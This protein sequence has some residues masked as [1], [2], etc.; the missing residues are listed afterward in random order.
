MV[1]GALVGT[2]VNIGV[3]ATGVLGPGMEEL[4]SEQVA[5]FAKIDAKLESLR[6]ASAD[7]AQAK[8]IAG[9]LQALIAHQKALAERTAEELRGA[10]AQIE[11]LQ[12]ELLEVR[13]ATRGVDL[14]LREGEG[15]TIGQKG[16]VFSVL[17][18]R[19]GAAIVNA[20]GE[21]KSLAPGGAVEFK[22]GSDTWRV[23]YKLAE[24]RA[25]RRV[26]F[27]VVKVEQ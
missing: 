16:N 3:S 8:S 21:R 15:A 20:G 11:Q 22:A 6:A 12:G 18:L 27:D 23:I 24:R 7:P 25:D 9:E 14:W 1:V 5:G 2:V 19:S 13:G 10:R 4:I 17:D 26:G